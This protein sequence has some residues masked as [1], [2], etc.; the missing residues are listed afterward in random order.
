MVFPGSEACA[1][2]LRV[3]SRP[4]HAVPRST[5]VSHVVSFEANIKK[6]NDKEKSKAL[7]AVTDNPGE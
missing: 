3:F 7:F 5:L 1:A 6:L 2:L 4:C